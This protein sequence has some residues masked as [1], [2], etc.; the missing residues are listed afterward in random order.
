MNA[1]IDLQGGFLESLK[2]L[3]LQPGFAKAL[4]IPIPSI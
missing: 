3:G 1:G 2:Q 4:W